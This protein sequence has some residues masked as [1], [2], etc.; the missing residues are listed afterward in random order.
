MTPDCGLPIDRVHTGDCL[1]LFARVR[2]GTVDLVFADP[3][4]NIGYDYDVYDD[5]RRGRAAV[6]RA[7]GVCARGRRLVVPPRRR[8][9]DGAGR[10]ARLA[11]AR[12]AVGWDRPRVL[13][14]GRGGP[15][16]VRREG[17]DPG[18]G[19]D[20]APAVS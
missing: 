10:L 8:H 7:G 2:T 6:G 17:W 12:A 1:D 3:P 15:R 14:P 4:F 13:G 11:D 19:D 5:R 9:V 18:R 20:A 16:P